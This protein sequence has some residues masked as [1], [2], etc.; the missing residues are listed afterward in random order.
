MAP[1]R[2]VTDSAQ[3]RLGHGLVT[4]LSIGGAT[5][6]ESG[7]VVMVAVLVVAMVTLFAVVILGSA[8]LA[9]SAICERRS[10]RARAEDDFFVPSRVYIDERYGSADADATRMTGYLGPS[11]TFAYH[12]VLGTSGSVVAWQ[13]RHRARVAAWRVR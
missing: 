7:A 5:S 8:A 3:R 2:L 11:P 4:V 12:A 6:L 1:A 13:Q 9:V 10:W